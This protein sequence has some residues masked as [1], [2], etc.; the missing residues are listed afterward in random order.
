MDAEKVKNGEWSLAELYESFD[1]PAFAADMKEFERLVALSDEQSRDLM[2]E[3]REVLLRMV[4]TREKLTDLIGKLMLYVSL[5]Q[6]ACTTDAQA[7]SLLDQ[8]SAKL[9]LLAAPETRMGEYV[10]GL[11]DLE[12]VIASDPLLTEY[13]YMFRCMKEDA[14]HLLDAKSEEIIALY[15]NTGSGAWGNLQ[16]YLTSTVPVEYRGG[17]ITLSDVRNLAY[18]PVPEVRKD[19]FHAELKAYERIRDAVAFS[20]NSIK[21][22]V[23]N[24]CRLKGF[25]SPLAETLHQSRMSKATLDALLEAIREYLPRIQPYFRHKA[26]LLGHEGGLPWYD[27]FAP[28]G[29]SDEKYSREDA[30]NYLVERF[31]TFDGE[32]TEMVRTAFEEG[33]ID[34]YPREGKVGGAFC[35]EA[36]P[37]RASRILTN[38]AGSFDDVVTLAHELGHAFHNLNLYD[39]RPLNRDYSMPV[40]ETAS[41]FNEVL[42]MNDAIRREQDP[43][44]RRALINEQLTGDTQIIC[45]IYSRFRFE[46]AVFESRDENF[47]FAPQL[48][49]LM[50]KAQKEGYGDGLDWAEP[51]PYMWV[52]KSHYYSGGLSFYNWP[53]AFGGLLAR[54]LYAAYEKDGAAFVPGYK[55]FLKA[56]AVMSVEDAGKVAGIDLTDPAFWRSGLEA[57][58]GEVEEF[59]RLCELG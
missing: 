4:E 55:R 5:R 20:L 27:L 3:P 38:F 49:D 44:R 13:G 40:A 19:A 26:K 45:D 14:K 42:V 53:Y 22:E 34:F 16:G 28:L 17:T 18:D 35:A 52:C 41:N 51:H 39:N 21:L 10:A 11:S 59:G 29:S 24:R 43:I 46:S 23:L 56:T 6:S 58:A 37:I 32:L 1:D 31:S 47:L 50:L 30:K 33:W 9:S 2:G 12:A 8:L 54:G 36:F 7:S 57:L 15:E 25:E 48:C